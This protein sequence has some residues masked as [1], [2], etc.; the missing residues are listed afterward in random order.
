MSKY[1]VKIFTGD[2]IVVEKQINEWFEEIA[3]KDI[4]VSFE[5]IQQTE[6]VSIAK[7]QYG[8]SDKKP[9]TISIF[10]EEG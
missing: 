7:N 4:Y 1:K 6:S 10:Y 5:N 2:K 9:F 3:E 8:S